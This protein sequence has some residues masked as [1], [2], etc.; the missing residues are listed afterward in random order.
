MTLYIES[1][2]GRQDTINATGNTQVNLIVVVLTLENVIFSLHRIY[3]TCGSEH[4]IRYKDYLLVLLRNNEV[5]E[6][7][8]R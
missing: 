4:L 7:S 2:G 5:C 6:I 1:L 3:R 8:N